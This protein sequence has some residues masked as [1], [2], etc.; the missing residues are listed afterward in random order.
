MEET[1]RLAVRMARCPYRGW[2]TQDNWHA[3]PSVE[4]FKKDDTCK[5]NQIDQIQHPLGLASGTFAEKAA[6]ALS[7]GEV[8]VGTSKVMDSTAIWDQWDEG[9]SKGCGEQEVLMP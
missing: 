6:D 9:I 1:G 7:K 2:K 3:R 5:I 8:G 4:T